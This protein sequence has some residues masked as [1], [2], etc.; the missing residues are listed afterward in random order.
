[1]LNVVV[2]LQNF[3]VNLPLKHKALDLVISTLSKFGAANRT[4]WPRV[5][6]D[7]QQG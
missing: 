2:F 4:G 7:L 1:M 3:K 6:P 5:Y